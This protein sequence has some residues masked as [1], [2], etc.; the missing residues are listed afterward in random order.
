M[1]YNKIVLEKKIK[2]RLN[3]EEKSNINEQNFIRNVFRFYIW[4]NIE[5][6][7]R[8]LH[9][10]YSKLQIARRKIEEME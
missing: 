9:K 1:L 3:N 7:A 8:K 4:I 6:I 5:I 2:G 10:K